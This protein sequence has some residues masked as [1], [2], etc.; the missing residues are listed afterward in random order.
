MSQIVKHENKNL[1]MQS[2]M[3][4]SGLKFFYIHLK[5]IDADQLI[6]E[7]QLICAFDLTYEPGH[8]KSNILHY[9]KTKAQIS[10]VVTVK[11]ITPLFSQHG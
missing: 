10:F 5:T 2:K 9:V 1:S 6:W 8:E 11:L 7:V 3:L 4:A